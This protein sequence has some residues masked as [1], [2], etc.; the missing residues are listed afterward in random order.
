[1]IRSRRPQSRSRKGSIVWPASACRS[2]GL[3]HWPESHVGLHAQNKCHQRLEFQR[4]AFFVVLILTFIAKNFTRPAASVRQCRT[5]FFGREQ[6]RKL[7]GS[8]PGPASSFSCG[9]CSPRTSFRWDAN[10]PRILVVH[11][12]LCRCRAD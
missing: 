2:A 8:F 7:V 12:L 3:V 6:L 1:P 4:S 10:A 11:R 9:E 5:V